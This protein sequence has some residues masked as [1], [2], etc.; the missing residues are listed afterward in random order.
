MQACI[1]ECQPNTSQGNYSEGFWRITSKINAN[2]EVRK[3]LE[4]GHANRRSPNSVPEF[5]L[6]FAFRRQILA[7]F[8]EFYQQI[9]VCLSL[10]RYFFGNRGNKA[11]K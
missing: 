10:I 5:C 1:D 9:H 2:I 6:R 8:D 3:H 4:S 7:Y 11:S